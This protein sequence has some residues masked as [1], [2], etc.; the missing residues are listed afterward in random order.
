MM[1]KQFLLNLFFPKG[2]VEY[3]AVY[4][5]FWKE[6]YFERKW[7]NIA[8]IKLLILLTIFMASKYVLIE[9]LNPSTTM[10]IVLYDWFNLTLANQR[11]LSLMT[12]AGILL[13]SCLLQLCYL[14][15]E[16]VSFLALEEMLFK[17]R[18]STFLW[19]N[20]RGQNACQ[21]LINFANRLLKTNTVVLSFVCK[22]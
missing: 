6:I 1:I 7:K 2:N 21:Y 11:G 14:K 17:N 16:P 22:Y 10:R 3:F 5:N 19:V 12:A 15:G 8:I 18:S 20:Y 4:L 13:I 9:L